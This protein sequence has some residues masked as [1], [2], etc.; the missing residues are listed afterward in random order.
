MS[1]HSF[2]VNDTEVHLSGRGQHTIVMLHGWPDSYRLWD[3]M[4]EALSL[5]HI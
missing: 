2:F 1:E 4:V 3:G 5:I